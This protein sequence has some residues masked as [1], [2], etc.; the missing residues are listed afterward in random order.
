M[1][2]GQAAPILSTHLSWMKG[3]KN[4]SA[5]EKRL[6]LHS[7]CVQHFYFIYEEEDENSNTP[8]NIDEANF[9]DEV[10]EEMGIWFTSSRR[11]IRSFT[12]H[13]FQFQINMFLKTVKYV[14]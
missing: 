12:S 9:D 10:S 4:C 1:R 14:N 3:V 5:K 8:C 11:F 2:L 7:L 6:F 13:F